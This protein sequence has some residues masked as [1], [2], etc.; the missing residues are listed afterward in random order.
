MNYWGFIII[1]AIIVAF[2]NWKKIIKLFKKG[3]LP[4]IVYNITK[5]FYPLTSKKYLILKQMNIKR[6][7]LNKTPLIAD[8]YLT[9]LAQNRCDEIDIDN[10]LSHKGFDEEIGLMLF[11]GA[12]EVGENIAYGY[13]NVESLMEAWYKSEG[14]FRNLMNPNWEICG[15]GVK[16]DENGRYIYCVLFT[17]D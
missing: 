13:R 6:K 14:H 12:S 5:I 15:I 10:E 2:F 4:N 16:K 1:G 8:V 9:S 7:Y 17:R 3:E 11:V